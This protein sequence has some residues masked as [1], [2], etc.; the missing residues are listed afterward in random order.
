VSSFNQWIDAYVDLCKQAKPADQAAE[1]DFETAL[2]KLIL[3][4]LSGNAANSEIARSLKNDIGLNA[5]GLA[6]WWRATQNG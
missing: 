6:H 3:T 4:G 5:Q 2:G 1:Q